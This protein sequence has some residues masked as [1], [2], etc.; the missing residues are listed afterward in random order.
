MLGGGHR[1]GGRGAV[2]TSPVPQSTTAWSWHAGSA[3]ADC[4]M[5]PTTQ[6]LSR[7]P[8]CSQ[9]TGE[10]QQGTWEGPGGLWGGA[11]RMSPCVAAPKHNPHGS[12]LSGGLSG[13]RC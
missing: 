4:Q 13:A 6:P 3:V 12:C 11:L 9:H 5:R 8:P 10:A 2:A 7:D 1:P